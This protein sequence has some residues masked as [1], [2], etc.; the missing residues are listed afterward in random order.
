MLVL[1]RKQD[2]SILLRVPGRKDPISITVV[3]ID[4]NNRVRLGI[5]AAKE[6]TVLR[7]ELDKA[8]DVVLEDVL[9]NPKAV[10][11]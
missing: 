4:N 5:D 1:S 11:V 6:V 9:L 8:T 7:A 3:R 2:Q 10:M